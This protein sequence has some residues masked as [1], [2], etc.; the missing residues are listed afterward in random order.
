MAT[1]RRWLIVRASGEMRVIKTNPQLGFDEVAF[2]IRVTLPDTWGKIQAQS[3]DLEI[4]ESDLSISI[5]A[6]TV[7]VGQHMRD[8][9]NEASDLVPE[10]EE[11]DD[12]KPA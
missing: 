8:E 10:S 9:H 7:N 6:G 4:R 1:Y 11:A 12:A 2:P 3:L 5:E